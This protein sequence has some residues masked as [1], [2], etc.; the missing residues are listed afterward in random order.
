M[1][2]YDLVLGY[3]ADHALPLLRVDVFRKRQQI[4]MDETA[5]HETRPWKLYTTCRS[6]ASNQYDN[7]EYAYRI[8]NPLHN[9]STP[10]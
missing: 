10:K 2:S 3:R 8:P 7:E 4:E 6:R 1:A 9:P 5:N